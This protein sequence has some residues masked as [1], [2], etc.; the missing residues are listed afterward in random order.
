MRDAD[1]RKRNSRLTTGRKFSMSGLLAGVALVLLL[2]RV[3]LAD[4][5]TPLGGGWSRYTNAR[6]G[7]VIEVPLQTFAAAEPAPEDGDGRV[8]R[9]HDGSRLS[10]YGTYAPYA[11]MMRFD[12]YTASLLADAQRRGLEVTYRKGGKGWIVFSGHQGG[13]IVYTKVVEGCEAVHE[14]VIAYPAA[15]K[16]LYDPVVARL[17]RTL[18]CRR[19]Q[20]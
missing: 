15:K 12:E 6:F 17:S 5:W 19:V 13:D 18:S 8:F 4:N 1:Q 7:T 9:A 11:V 2:T 10:V 20:R 14:L 3:A 16:T